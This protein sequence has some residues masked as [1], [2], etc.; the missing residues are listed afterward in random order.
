ML[1]MRAYW[2][3]LVSN[4]VFRYAVDRGLV[5]CL[6]HIIYTY[7]TV[8]IKWSEPVASSPFIAFRY[9]VDRGLVAGVS[10][11]TRV[12]IQCPCGPVTAYVTY[13][14]NVTSGVRFT[15]VPSYVFALGKYPLESCKGK[16]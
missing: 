8:F 9:A 10:P 3:K 5:G 4:L 2:F 12:V 16:Q 7:D 14:D 1:N 15:S 11:E 6:L 13:R